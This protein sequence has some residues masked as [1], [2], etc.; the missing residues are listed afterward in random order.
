MPG[1]P[2]IPY[3]PKVIFEELDEDGVPVVA[4][5]VEVSCDFQTVELTPD[6]P[7]N[8]VPTFCGTFQ[9]PG[10]VTWSAS[11][12]VV[13]LDDTSTRWAPLVGKLVNVKVW[14]R[15][16]ST[17]SRQFRS[18]IGFDPSLGGPTDPEASGRTLE[19]DVAVLT[20]PVWV[21]GAYAAP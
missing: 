21:V 20:T 2:I 4:G 17:S 6:Q 18:Q 5:A 19:F 11:F 3:R 15:A 7:I 13:V 10:D 14:D 8:N 16:T 9:T 1:S 12:G